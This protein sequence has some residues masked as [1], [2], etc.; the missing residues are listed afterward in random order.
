MAAW[1][2]FAILVFGIPAVFGFIQL[3]FVALIVLGVIFLVFYI[4]SK[5]G[6]KM[7]D[8]KD[9]VRLQ[10]TLKEYF[11]KHP[12]LNREDYNI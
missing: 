8:N 4:F 12:E 9:E 1:L 10:K 2:L 7:Q 11:E 6:Q 5:Q 3:A